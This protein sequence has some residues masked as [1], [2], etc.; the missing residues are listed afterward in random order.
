[1]G[2]TGLRGPDH[3]QDACRRPRV[4]YAGDQLARDRSGRAAELAHTRPVH[5]SDKY[6][7]RGVGTHEAGHVFGLDHVEG[8]DHSN[9]TMYPKL[10]ECTE[11]WRT[12]GYGDVRG[13]RSLY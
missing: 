10:G 7:L 9:L 2:R 1:M 12:L 13:L 3:A 6:D 8:S 5:C 4:E 11:K